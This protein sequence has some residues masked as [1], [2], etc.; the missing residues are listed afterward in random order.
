M[1][2]AALVPT[3]V[4]NIYLFSSMTAELLVGVGL[5]L[6]LSI[7]LCVLMV[8]AAKDVYLLTGRL[9]G[10]RSRVARADRTQRE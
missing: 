2:V 3:I 7:M 5:D 6:L 10:V 4:T 1:M 8:S 9:G